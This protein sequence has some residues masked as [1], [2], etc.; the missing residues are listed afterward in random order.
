MT[1]K[2][3]VYRILFKSIYFYYFSILY[4]YISAILDFLF[5]VSELFIYLSNLS[6]VLITTAHG[7]SRFYPDDTGPSASRKNSL[8]IVE[9]NIQIP[10]L[11][12]I[13]STGEQFKA[14]TIV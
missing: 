10:L 14:S 11:L 6:F 3:S 7:L 5:W 9:V 8:I 2:I 4:Q 13:G 1:A 12:I